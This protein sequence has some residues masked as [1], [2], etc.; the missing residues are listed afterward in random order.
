[1]REALKRRWA[2]RNGRKQAAIGA[3]SLLLV[4]G[5]AYAYLWQPVERERDRLLA[6]VPQLRAEAKAVERDMQELERLKESVIA[7]PA[8]RA[9]IQQAA[10][11]SRLP[12]TSFRFTAQ[13]SNTARIVIASASA[14]QAFTWA[15][16]L[17]SITG[18][19]IENLRMASLGD[20]DLVRV[21]AVLLK[22][23]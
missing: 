4:I 13:D 19:R 1:M 11:A 18:V 10:A 14:E 20:G 3:A 5:L 7:S 12:D 6:R 2:D 21:Q 17:G 22:V 23:R 8:L 15:A 16:R 9:A